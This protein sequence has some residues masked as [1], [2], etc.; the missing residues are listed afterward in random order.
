MAEGRQH[1][2]EQQWHA[3]SQ[4]HQRVFH[5]GVAPLRP[6]AP[7]T[8]QQE[9]RRQGGF[10]EQVEQGPVPGHE[11]PGMADSGS[12]TGNNDHFGRSW[13]LA[14]ASN[15]AS[16]CKRYASPGRQAVSVIVL[17]A[18]IPAGLACPFEGLFLYPQ[19]ALAD[20]VR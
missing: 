12:R 9:Q 16:G 18:G 20:V 1:A 3:T 6:D 2:T 8:D 17:Q 13:M 11:Y 15:A 19:V 7:D 5:C 10:P 14:G 4:H